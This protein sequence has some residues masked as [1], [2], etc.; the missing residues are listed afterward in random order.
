MTI[1]DRQHQLLSHINAHWQTKSYAPSVRDLSDAMGGISTNAVH[2]HLKACSKKGLVA[3]T[4]K[5]A[6]SIILTHAGEAV[7]A[8]AGAYL[9][10]A[11]DPIK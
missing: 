5:V 10:R 3:Q 1:T 9:R 11:T 6:R 2:N 8:N 7:I 4:P